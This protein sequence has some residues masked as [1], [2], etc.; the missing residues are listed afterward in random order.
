MGSLRRGLPLLLLGLLLAYLAVVPLVLLTLSSFKPE[1]FL[2]DEGW[3]L[4][5]WRAVYLG[6]DLWPM[7]RNT[8]VFA[9]GSTAAALLMGTLLAWLVERTD[10]PG[11]GIV[12]VMIV[13]PLAT[14]PLLLAIAWVLL[15]SPRTGFFNFALMDL[16]GL[17]T[18]PLN[19]F[20]MGGMIFVE[21]MVLLPSVYLMLAPAFR[22]MDPNL[23]HAAFVSGASVWTVVTRIVLPLLRPAILA[24]AVFML[25]VCLVV[26]DV[27]GAI[28][29][30]VRVF[31][32]ST[33][34]YI[35]ATESPT[36]LPLYGQ[37]AALAALFVVVLV[38]L[39]VVYQQL[40]LQGQRF[41]TVSGKGFRPRPMPL[42]RWRWPAAAMVWVYFF[43]ATIAPLAVLL[44]TSLLP[45]QTRITWE[46]LGGLT[47]E[48][49]LAFL[50]N[51]RLVLAVK[52]TAVVALV[53]AT[54]VALLSLLVSWAVV[55][56]KA[57][58]R[59]VLDLLAFL[60]MGIPGVMI[61]VALITVYLTFTAIPIYGTIWILVVAYTTTFIAYGTRTTN[62]VML[63]LHRD[64]EEAASVAGAGYWRIL[65]RIV[66]P[67]ALP[68]VVAVWVWV[69]AHAAREL[70]TALMLHGR[71]NTVISTLLWNFWSGGDGPRAAAV[72]VW[73][74]VALFLLVGCW[75]LLARRQEAR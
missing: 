34:I 42:G 45:F 8:V 41:A 33:L 14:P 65:R 27:P 56:S 50:G 7:L 67:L 4:D 68:A 19:I 29:M 6:R 53:S 51:P 71:N 17:Q 52:N 9:L 12:R 43:L 35:W 20:S 60:P 1:G 36:G 15:L 70:S 37:V 49:H 55:R 31:V 46:V 64:L 59:Y 10:L 61:G 16:L 26:F 40:S 57:R 23:E 58:G 32:V 74:M 22:N 2:D 73:L 38:G 48:N 28:G 24:A 66:L 3:V 72:G 63:Q 25:I 47:W 13:L 39:G 62:G 54:A 75:Q 69:M 44:V 18:A 11:R 30:P 5:N 21:A